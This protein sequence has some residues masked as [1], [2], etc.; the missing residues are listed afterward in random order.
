MLIF[1]GKNELGQSDKAEQNHSGEV[2]L[3]VD[4]S[5]REDLQRRVERVC[6]TADGIYYGDCPLSSFLSS[7][8]ISAHDGA[9]QRCKNPSMLREPRTLPSGENALETKRDS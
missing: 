6:L 5:V 9:G 2:T 3:R 1:L 4:P 7:A 8:S